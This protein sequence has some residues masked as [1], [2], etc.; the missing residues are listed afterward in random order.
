MKV[1]WGKFLVQAYR[2]CQEADGKLGE[3]AVRIQ[4]CWMR[5]EGQLELTKQLEGHM[6]DDLR[7]MQRRVLC[8]LQT[9]LRVAV[10]KAEWIGKP[11]PPLSPRTRDHCQLLPRSGM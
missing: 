10:D 5:V 3:M 9:N 1:R 8:I 6:P 4:L 11:G 7:A 2:S